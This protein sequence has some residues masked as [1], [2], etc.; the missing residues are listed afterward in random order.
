[1]QAAAADLGA[2]NV[3]VDLSNTNGSYTTG[4]T[5]DGNLT[6]SETRAEPV[7]GG[8]SG[9]WAAVRAITETVTIP[10]GSGSDPVVQTSGN[11][12]PANSLIFGATARVTTAPGGGA[13]TLDIGTSGNTDLL[14]NDMST[15]GDTTATSPA[16]GDATQFPVT[17][18]AAAK[19]TLTTDADVTVSGMVVKV[20]V[21]YLVFSAQ[22]SLNDPPD[23]EFDTGIMGT[24]SCYS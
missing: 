13:T 3:T 1:L 5:V 23:C 11:L 6:A 2:A 15:A 18:A 24:D 17:N 21:W 7:I 22:L 12:A 10:V 19:L 8:G 9:A 14:V 20:T 4:L 16:N